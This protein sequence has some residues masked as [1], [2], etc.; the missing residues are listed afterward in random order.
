[1]SVPTVTLRRP[2]DG[3]GYPLHELVARCQPLDVNSVYCNLLQCSDFADTSIAAVNADGHLVGFISGYCPPAR[4]DTLFVWQVAVDSSMRGQGLALRM[5]MALVARVAK[6][7]GI[8]NLETTISPDNGASQALFKKA[9]A[10]LGVDYSTR[11]LFARAEHF[12]GKHEDEVLYRAG[13]FAAPHSE[14]ELEET[15]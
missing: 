11:T 8:R 2:N 6:E 5:L 1:M 13:P 14:E 7:Q 12:A 10:K 3:D 15:A 9:F 4:P